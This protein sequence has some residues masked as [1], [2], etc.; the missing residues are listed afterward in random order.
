VERSTASKV[1]VLLHCATCA[2]LYRVGKVVVEQTDPQFPSRQKIGAGPKLSWQKSVSKGERRFRID[3]FTLRLGPG[4]LPGR[5][6]PTP[7]I[8][9]VGE[10]RRK[11]HPPIQIDIARFYGLDRIVPLIAPMVS[12]SHSRYF[13]ARV[14]PS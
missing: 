13:H 11:Q 10:A 7:S 9:V 12:R 5:E 6:P 1:R 2:T 4:G 14:F 3:R 8:A